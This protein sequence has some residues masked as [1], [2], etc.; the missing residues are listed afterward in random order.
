MIWL[1]L[2]NLYLDTELEDSDFQ[3]IASTI[4]ATSYSFE[5]VVEIDKYEVFPVL[6]Y[7]L[8]SVAGVW[9]SFDE[10]WLVEKIMARQNNRSKFND[11]L[12]QLSYALHRRIHT[13]Y[14]KRI[15]SAY[16]EER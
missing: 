2:S 6:R 16:K 8:S 3:N 14:W 12:I 4:H 15:E 13:K 11:W 9:D 7:N 1:S 10:I 5:E